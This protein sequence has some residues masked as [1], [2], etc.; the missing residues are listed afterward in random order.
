MKRENLFE[1]ATM[2]ALGLLDG[3][4]RRAFEDAFRAASPALQEELRREQRRLTDLDSTLPRVEP[5]ASLRERVLAAVRDAIAAVSPA[6]TGLALA[7]VGATDWAAVRRQVSPLWRAACIG[8][9][10]ATVVLVAVGFHISATYRSA[11]QDF[12]DTKLTQ[13]MTQQLGH[14]FAERFLDPLTQKVSFTP[15][16]DS[17]SA[18]AA[19]LIDPESRTAYLVTRDLPAVAGEYRLVILDDAGKIDRSVTTFAA[20][21]MLSGRLIEAEITPGM[22]L[23]IVPPAAGAEAGPILRSL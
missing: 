22:G 9:A 11:V 4:E 15:V 7:R 6:R 14:E 3:E 17:V 21:G 13:L 18:R 1:M 16:S 2:D 19:I 8:F 20:N 23:A 5:P 10:T 12:N